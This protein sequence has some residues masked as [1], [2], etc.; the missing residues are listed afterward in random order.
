MSGDHNFA[1]TPATLTMV[2]IYYIG[3]DFQSGLLSTM[4][5][6]RV[7]VAT[8]WVVPS[9]NRMGHI[10]GY[11]DNFSRICSVTLPIYIKHCENL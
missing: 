11:I 6:I 5:M 3:S 10:I 9:S 8:G 2:M 7:V 4:I 1:K